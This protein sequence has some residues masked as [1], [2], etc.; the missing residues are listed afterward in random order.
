MSNNQ[1]DSQVLKH[2]QTLVD[3]EHGLYRQTDLDD[4][5][6]RRLASLQVELDRCWDLLRQRRALRE[7][8]EDPTPHVSGPHLSSSATNSKFFRVT[9]RYRAFTTGTS[10]V[11]GMCGNRSLTILCTLRKERETAQA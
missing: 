6:R 9:N 11:L 10:P 3:E 5:G 7:F 2:I 1:S 4:D 8:G